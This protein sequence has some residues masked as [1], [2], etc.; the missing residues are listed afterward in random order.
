MGIEKRLPYVQECSR[1]GGDFFDAV[2]ILDKGEDSQR[3]AALISHRCGYRSRIELLLLQLVIVAT[4]ARDVQGV[5][6]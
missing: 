1:M 2:R 4:D 3:A 6:D 5:V